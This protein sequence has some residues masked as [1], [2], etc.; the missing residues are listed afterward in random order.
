MKETEA[1][2]HLCVSAG[3]CM[4]YPDEAAKRRSIEEML[5]AMDIYAITISDESTLEKPF[6]K[7]ITITL[8]GDLKVKQ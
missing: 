5:N 7:K 8:S 2:E 6:P 1:W 3:E 4:G